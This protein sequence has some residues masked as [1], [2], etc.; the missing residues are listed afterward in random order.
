MV[1]VLTCR[2]KNCGFD[3]RL[4][5]KKSYKNMTYNLL[6]KKLLRHN[7]IGTKAVNSIYT[8]LGLNPR[9]RSIN[10]RSLQLN[11]IN[12]AVNKLSY[13]KT[14]KTKINSIINYYIKLKNY[15]G[16]RHLMRYPVRGQRTHT[17]AKTIRMKKKILKPN[18]T[19]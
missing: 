3:S 16:V 17:N 18:E 10:Y 9:L 6:K 14:F 15:R 13:K 2:V 7:G 11:R 4:S 12:K 8:N 5:R 19:K 1:K